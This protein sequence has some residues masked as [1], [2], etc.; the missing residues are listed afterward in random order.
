L[1]SRKAHK[2]FTSTCIY[3]KSTSI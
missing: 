2:I 1:Q 3:L